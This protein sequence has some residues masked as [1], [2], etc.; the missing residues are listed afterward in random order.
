MVPAMSRVIIKVM[1]IEGELISFL[2]K[3]TFKVQKTAKK[4]RKLEIQYES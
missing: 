4:S 3:I 1:S 2:W